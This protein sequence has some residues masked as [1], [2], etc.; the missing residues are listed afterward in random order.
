MEGSVNGKKAR[1]IRKA[2]Q[3]NGKLDL[4]TPDYRVSKERKKVVYDSE[5]VDGLMVN[6]ART[7]TL[8]S[9]V[10]INRLQYRN[11]K[12]VF[13]DMPRPSRSVIQENPKQEQE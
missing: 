4:K 5:M 11:F 8:Q 12:K 9:I 10:N 3:L 13:N 7:I 2:A 6:K 1:A